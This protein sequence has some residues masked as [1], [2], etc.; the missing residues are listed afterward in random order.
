[1][2]NKHRY[3]Q[4]ILHMIGDDHIT[5][6]NLHGKLQKL[7]PY[8]GLGTVYRNLTELVEEEKI[9]KTSGLIE[10]TVY[11]QMKPVHGH[12][13]CKWSTKIYDISIDMI[14]LEKVNLPEN[15]KLEEITISFY[16]YF[17]E[18]K[19]ACTATMKADK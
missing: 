8:I 1:M 7:Y 13:V 2:A 5:A 11:E 14:D 3:K 9:M 15:F 4:E 16:G 10:H 18:G 12:I 6:Q 19:R 17:G